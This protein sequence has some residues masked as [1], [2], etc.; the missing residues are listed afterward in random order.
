MLGSSIFTIFYAM[1]LL[2]FGP[3]SEKTGRKKILIT[4]FLLSSITTGL[5]GFA[6]TEWTIYLFRGIQ[7]FALG[8]FAPVAFAYTF[9]LFQLK[10]RTVVLSL[11]NSG[12]LVAGILGQLI[13]ST[14]TQLYGWEF[15]FFVFA[16]IY[17]ILFL[18]GISVLPRNHKKTTNNHSIFKD[19]LSLL[20][21]RA[22]LICYSIT[23]TV[24]FTFVAFYDGLGHFL[25]TEFSVS[26][27]T[28]FTIR[29]IGLIG[30]TLSLFTNKF[31][32]KF[33]EKRT[34]VYGL[35]LT[36]GSLIPIFFTKTLLIVAILTI[37]F[38]ASL[39]L[40]YPAII[41]IIGSIGNK[42]RGSAISLYS[43]TLLIGASFGPP[44]ASLLH[45]KPL[46]LLLIGIFITNILFGFQLKVSRG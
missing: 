27:E 41:S 12:F 13:S 32:Q 15:V 20:K 11:I 44:L 4:G 34:L 6:S 37:P 39:S 2:T 33:G 18:I 35:I 26:D 5:V 21:N 28:I 19:A 8:S 43:F 23:F 40:L 36:V 22:L 3:L 42:S 16:W 17:F 46:L 31:V 24:L 38:V 7:G 25:K 9:E 14:I 10:K 30:A 29:A 1:G 45:F